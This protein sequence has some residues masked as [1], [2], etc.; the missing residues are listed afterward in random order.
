[1]SCTNISPLESS[2]T[3]HCKQRQKNQPMGRQHVACTPGTH[4]S[5]SLF[6]VFLCCQTKTISNISHSAF[7]FKANILQYH[8]LQPQACNPS[9][10]SNIHIKINSMTR[11]ATDIQVAVFLQAT[12]TDNYSIKIIAFSHLDRPDS[13]SVQPPLLHYYLCVCVHTARLAEKCSSA[14]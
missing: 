2:E 14:V 1:M 10:K 3:L 9:K 5:Q 8:G 7:L 12:S 4:I 13:L 11:S 6:F